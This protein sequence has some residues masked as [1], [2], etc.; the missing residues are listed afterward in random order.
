MPVGLTAPPTV[1]LLAP[2]LEQLLA[3]SREQ[4]GL[5]AQKSHLNTAISKQLKDK[6]HVLDHL[7]DESQLIPAHPIP[8]AQAANTAFTDATSGTDGSGPSALVKP[9]VFAADSAKIST[10]EAVA[11]KIEEGQIA[12][13][14]SMRALGELDEVLGQEPFGQQD[15]LDGLGEDDLWLEDGQPAGRTTGARKHTISKA[16]KPAQPGTLWD[17]LDGNL[18]LLRSEKDTP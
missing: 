12:L 11:E 9:W 7:A 5:I 6:R 3:V 15:E 18:G 8:G 4:K 13:E 10:L 14:G 17:T 1:H 16:N 2:Y